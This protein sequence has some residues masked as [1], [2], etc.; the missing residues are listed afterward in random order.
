VV[1]EIPP[2]KGE[3]KSMISL[4]HSQQERVRL[5]LA[6]AS[7]VTVD[8]EWLVGAISL[9]ATVSA[10]GGIGCPMPPT[11]LGGIADV[12]QARSTGADLEH[13]GP[14]AQVACYS[15]DAQIQELH[16]RRRVDD[17]DI[18]YAIVI[19]SLSE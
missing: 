2:A 13:H 11:M 10:P 8:R 5:L 12:L 1:G 16:Y 9:E 15:D 7:D 19:R 18:G 17:D 6:E 3:A 4:G 14:L